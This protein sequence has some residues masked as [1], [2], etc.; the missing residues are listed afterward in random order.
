LPTEQEIER[1]FDITPDEEELGDDEG[2][3][4]ESFEFTVPLEQEHLE[5]LEQYNELIRDEVNCPDDTP[6]QIY[7]FLQEKG[8][9][10]YPFG[11]WHECCQS[12]INRDFALAFIIV[13]MSEMAIS[14]HESIH[15]F[16]ST[17]LEAVNGIFEFEEDAYQLLNSAI[18]ISRL[19]LMCYVSVERQIMV[20][21]LLDN[22]LETI[23]RGDEQMDQRLFAIE[24]VY[25]KL[26]SDN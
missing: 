1:F 21:A 17:G 20:S 22:Y 12:S 16:F 13:M 25:F 26:I 7:D 18:G 23:D 24:E 3:D 2:G 5:A 10:Q 14:P 9:Q 6:T 15:A 4:D 19:K 8:E 11:F